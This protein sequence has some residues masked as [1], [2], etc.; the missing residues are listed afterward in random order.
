MKTTG[1]ESRTVALFRAKKNTG[2]ISMGG[3]LC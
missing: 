3:Y 1:I 2:A